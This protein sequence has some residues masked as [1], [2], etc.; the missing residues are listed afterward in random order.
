MEPSD[1]YHVRQQF[2]LGAY[3]SVANAT[4]PEP[5]SQDYLPLQLYKAR[6][7]IALGEPQHVEEFIPEE[8]ETLPLKAARSLAKYVA[9]TPERK[10]SALEELRDL[11]VE[12]EGEEVSEGDR[13]EVRVLAGTAFAREG[14]VE[15]ALETLGAG[16]SH[17]NLE[18]TALI[19]QIYLFIDRTDAAKKEYERALKWAEDDLLL[20]LI[21]ASIGLVT[22]GEGYS[23]AFSFYS[24]QLGN[25]SLT[26]PHLLTARGVTRLLRGEVPE[27]KSDLEEALKSEENAET[28]CA[29]IV[30]AGLGT[31]K[32]ADAD[33]L[34]SHLSEKFPTHPMVLDIAQKSKA[35]DE[36]VSKF[37]V[38]PPAVTASA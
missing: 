29:S 1:L 28:F 23:N 36:L 22:G 32:K 6:A 25:P 16:S 7:L 12:I 21:E 33:Q 5:S 10:D 15:E 8:S 9:A 13:G 24:E 4:L 30:A 20:Q 34:F 27:A 14:E 35:F 3:R 19:V 2:T 18:A 26:S 11:C 38:P 31:G 17:E 37:E